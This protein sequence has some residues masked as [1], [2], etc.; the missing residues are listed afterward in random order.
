MFYLLA[1]TPGSEI[2]TQNRL[3]RRR[4]SQAHSRTVVR[5]TAAVATM[6]GLGGSKPREC[7]RSLI[8]FS[9]R[10]SSSKSFNVEYAS[11]LKRIS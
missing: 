4:R 9:A 8:L 3:A 6:I 1:D 7:K 11:H 10:A 5:Y 2:S